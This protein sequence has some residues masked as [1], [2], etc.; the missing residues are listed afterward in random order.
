MALVLIGSIAA[1]TD[2][3]AASLVSGATQTRNAVDARVLEQVSAATATRTAIDERVRVGAADAVADAVADSS[4]VKAA[5][6][7]A[8]SDAAV[9]AQL[10]W[11][12]PPGSFPAGR[13]PDDMYRPEDN[14]L[15]RLASSF[16]EGLPADVPAGVRML[17]VESFND[18]ATQRLTVYGTT[19]KAERQMSNAYVTPP[20]WTAWLRDDWRYLG[21]LADNTDLDTLTSQSANGPYALSAARTYLNAPFTGAGQLRVENAG[22]GAGWMEAVEYSTGKTYRRPVTNAAANQW[23]AWWLVGPDTA[24]G[25]SA[26]VRLP[27][28]GAPLNADLNVLTMW[29]DSLTHAGGIRDQLAALLPDVTVSNRGASGQNSAHIAARQGGTPAMLTVAGG[30]IP[31]SGAVQVASRSTPLLIQSGNP[32][33]S[34]DGVLAGV[35]GTLSVASGG[36]AYTFTR[37]TDGVAVPIP[38]GAPFWTDHAVQARRGA[39][40]IWMGRNNIADPAPYDYLTSMIDFVSPAAKNIVVLS[41]TNSPD[42]GIGTERY[43]LFIRANDELKAMAGD[44]FLDVRRWLIDEGLAAA[45]ITPTSGDTAA[46]AVDAVPPS[47]TSDGIHFVAAAQTAIGTWLHGKLLELGWY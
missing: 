34:L 36:G 33:W 1:I 3:I 23:G 39:Q 10:A 38:N 5:A 7:M 9:Q 11:R 13:H 14:G 44:N 16:T 19:Y 32:A 8:M 20:D 4:T 21:S 2:A 12:K 22:T 15:W 25:Q 27:D 45:G 47:L 18:V 46:I 28:P 17:R 29:G 40:I 43:G 24:A 30:V 6:V 35:H 41:V 37:T 26:G 31:A 42:E